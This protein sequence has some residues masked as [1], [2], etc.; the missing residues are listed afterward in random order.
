MQKRANLGLQYEQVCIDKTKNGI[1][2]N[3]SI[4]MSQR[5][6]KENNGTR[7]RNGAKLP[8]IKGAET[9]KCHANNDELSINRRSE[10]TFTSVLVQRDTTHY[11]FNCRARLQNILEK[12]DT[13]HGI[14]QL[15]CAISLS[16][17]NLVFHCSLHHQI[18]ISLKDVLKSRTSIKEDLETPVDHKKARLDQ[19][20]DNAFS[21]LKIVSQSRAKDKQRHNAISTGSEAGKP[22][23]SAGSGSPNQSS[24]SW[25][26]E[27][28][29]LSCQ[30]VPP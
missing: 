20:I 30:S 24:E 16:G 11:I 6:S 12:A 4:V 14:N 26:W 3:G 29:W 23:R 17:N 8:Y 27:E 22:P 5:V 18:N 28:R 10:G 13:S 15:L 7:I 21:R 2:V 25:Y 9:S 1:G 19:K